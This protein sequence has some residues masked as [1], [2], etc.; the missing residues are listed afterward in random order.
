[1]DE[2]SRSYES[3][4]YK[5]ITRITIVATHCE[6]ELPKIVEK[7]TINVALAKEESSVRREIKR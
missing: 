1:M 6:I 4:I 2:D 7:S 5:T 3:R